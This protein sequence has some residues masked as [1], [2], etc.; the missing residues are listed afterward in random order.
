MAT[1]YSEDMLARL[2]GKR[3]NVGSVTKASK[4]VYD[5]RKKKK[6][7]KKSVVEQIGDMIFKG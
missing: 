6:K 2:E 1:S 4:E 5:K 3:G 7:K